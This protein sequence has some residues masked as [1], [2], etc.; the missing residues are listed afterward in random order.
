MKE[1]IWGVFIGNWIFWILLITLKKLSTVLS[2][3]LK[4]KY[5]Q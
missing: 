3:K 1:I 5:K 4:D 2:Q